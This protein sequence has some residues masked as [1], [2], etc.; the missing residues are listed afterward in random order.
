MFLHVL[1]AFPTQQNSVGQNAP[2]ALSTALY[3]MDLQSYMT[4]AHLAFVMI[5]LS[6]LIPYTVAKF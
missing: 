2:A 4:A 1:M 6:N 3:V 5:S